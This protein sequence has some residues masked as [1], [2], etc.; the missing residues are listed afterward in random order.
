MHRL[1]ENDDLA[2]FWDSD[3]CFHAK[4]CVHS[5]PETFDIKRRPWIDLSRCPDPEIWN[6]VSQCP[7]GALTIAY[8]HEVDV[9]MDME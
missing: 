3:K 9:I 1:Y 6:A 5:S 8:R 7:S 2:V 4:R